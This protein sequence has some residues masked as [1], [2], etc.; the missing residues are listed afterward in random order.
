MVLAMPTR[1]AIY[2]SKGGVGKTTTAVM[3]ADGLAHF[4]GLRV[5]VMDFDRQASASKMLI[6]KD[7]IEDA[8]LNKKT[9]LDVLGAF[10]SKEHNINKYIYTG[11]S[12][13]IE[14]RDTKEDNKLDMIPSI[15]IMHDELSDL[16]Q[17]LQSTMPEAPL[18]VIMHKHFDAVLKKL[19]KFYD[20]VII[21]CPAGQSPYALAA[22]R[23]ADHMIAPTVLEENSL[24]VLSDL[25][26]F[27][28]DD[29]GVDPKNKVGVLMC[30]VDEADENQMQMR[31]HMKG[32]L[33]NYETIYKY[34]PLRKSL[35]SAMQHPGMGNYRRLREKYEDNVKTVKDLAKSVVTRLNGHI[36]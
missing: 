12:D 23:L 26:T 13:L 14:L 31:K 33:Y 2:N 36:Q 16:E 19:D 20:I 5:L 11:A 8:T 17:S 28:E 30:Q 29:M 10:L 9:L 6:G 32:G 25:F 34:I 21:D 24:G 27:L 3:V 15:G 1:L 4:Q 35:R 22:I 7:G 18:D